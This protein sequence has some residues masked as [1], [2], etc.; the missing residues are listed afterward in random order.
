LDELTDDDLFH[1]GVPRPLIP[2]VRAIR[3]DAAFEEVAPYLPEEA[4][5]VLFWVAAGRSLDE[6]LRETLGTL[7][8]GAAR[9]ESPGDFSKLDQVGNFNLVLIEGE[10]ELRAI[11]AEDIEMWRVFLHPYQRKIVEWNAAGPIKINGAAGTGKTVA[12]MHRAVYL[13]KR[14]TDPK[15]KVLVTTFTTNL[16]VTI[17]HLIAQLSPEAAKRIEVTNLHQLARTICLQSEWRGR[18]ADDQEL[19]EIWDAMLPP[20]SETDEFNRQFVKEEYESVVDAMGIDT[21]EEYL[22]VVRDRTP[23]TVPAAA[24]EAVAEFSGFQPP[25]SEEGAPNLRGDDSPGPHDRRERPRREHRTSKISARS[26]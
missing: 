5:Q 12:L 3:T 14:L 23:K 24:S 20:A 9:P 21:E 16:S 18:I 1:A 15:D 26:R 4:Q 6:A 10:E 19:G 13:A 2:A 8:A 7:N 22:T 25:T 11:L 17:E